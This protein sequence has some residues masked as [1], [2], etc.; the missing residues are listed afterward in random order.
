[1]V[2]K[3]GKLVLMTPETKQEL[4]ERLCPSLKDMGL[5]ARLNLLMLKV[6]SLILQHNINLE[7]VKYKRYLR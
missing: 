2:K 6:E 3:E 4:L 5:V 1:M 7:S